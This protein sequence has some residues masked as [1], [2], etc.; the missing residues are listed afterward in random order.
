M[1]PGADPTIENEGGHKPV[2]YVRK[3]Q[4]RDMLDSGESKVG[5]EMKA[6]SLQ[7]YDF[8]IWALILNMYLQDTLTMIDHPTIVTSIGTESLLLNYI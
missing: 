5:N 4:I 8:K 2:A 3:P 7:L 1:F 6:S